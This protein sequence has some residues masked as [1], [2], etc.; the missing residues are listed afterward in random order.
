RG[1]MWPTRPAKA[2][3]IVENGVVTSFEITDGGAGYSSPPS[4]TVPGVANA[5]LEVQLSFGKQLD[6]NGSVTAINVENR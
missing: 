1:E 6:Q 2:V 4:V 5:A 3:A